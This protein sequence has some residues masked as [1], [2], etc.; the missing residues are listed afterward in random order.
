MHVLARHLAEDQPLYKWRYKS[1]P[2]VYSVMSPIHMIKVVLVLRLS[3][4]RLSPQFHVAF[5]PSFITINGRYGG[6]APP[7]YW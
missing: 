5:D 6:L 2:E 3:I 7:S 4:G 1:T